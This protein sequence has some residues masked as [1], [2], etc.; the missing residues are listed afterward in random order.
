MELGSCLQDISSTDGDEKWVDM[1]VH[2]VIECMAEFSECFCDKTL[3]LNSLIQKLKL[4]SGLKVELQWFACF[5]LAK[6]NVSAL[7]EIEFLKPI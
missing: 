6:G 1:Q 4:R 3:S 5:S 7:V 2:E